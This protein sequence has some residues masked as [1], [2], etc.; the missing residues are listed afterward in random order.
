MPRGIGRSKGQ[1]SIATTGFTI[2]GL[3]LSGA[4][5]GRSL[6]IW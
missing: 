6:D 2:S 1:Y 5:R 4:S 3:P